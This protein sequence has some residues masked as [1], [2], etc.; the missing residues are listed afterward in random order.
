MPEIK[1]LLQPD[2]VVEE[3]PADKAT[4]FICLDGESNSTT[5]SLADSLANSL[6][7]PVVIAFNG[8][9]DGRGFSLIKAL[10]QNLGYSGQV[11]ASGYINPDQL[12]FAFQCGF[13]GVLVNPD[14]WDAYGSEAWKS[15]LNP[16]VN[17]SYSVTESRPVRSIWQ[18][19]H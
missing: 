7:E 17:L 2:G 18:Q 9:A 8:V 5:E 3:L 11:Y 6:S 12:S 4:L 13:D 14:R 16:V 10:R 1:Y 15:A 19:R